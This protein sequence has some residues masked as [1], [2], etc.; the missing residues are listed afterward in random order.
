MHHNQVDYMPRMPDRS[1]IQA[2]LLIVITDSKQNKKTNHMIIS[3][4]AEKTFKK[5]KVLAN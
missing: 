1:Y 5:I 2:V 4:N 3:L